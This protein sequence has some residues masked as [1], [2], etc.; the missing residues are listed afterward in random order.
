MRLTFITHD[1]PWPPLHGGRVDMWSRL[2]E[3]KRRGHALQLLS[4]GAEMPSAAE[5]K[6]MRGLADEAF[7]FRSRRDILRFLHPRYPG[8]VRNR[9]W[10]SAD[11]KAMFSAV[12]RFRPDALIADGTAVGGAALQLLSKLDPTPPL[13]L[14]SHNV[15]WLY[16]AMLGHHEKNPVAKLAY[17]VESM[18]LRFFER[19]LMCRAQRIFQIAR[20]DQLYWQSL[21]YDHQFTVPFLF[22]PPQE[23]PVSI[24]KKYDVLYLGNLGSNHKLASLIWFMRQ[25]RPLLPSELTIGIAGAGAPD[26][27]ELLCREFNCAYVGNVPDPKLVLQSGRVLIN[28]VRETCGINVKM[29]EML[30]SRLP[31]VSTSAGIRSYPDGIQNWVRLADTPADFAASIVMA[32]DNPPSPKDPLPWLN[33]HFGPQTLDLFLAETEKTALERR[34]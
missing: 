33:E 31:I 3:L 2:V 9:M 24:S 22:A 12:R 7:F 8:T 4:W 18:R 19:G 1:H 29:A 27:F 14:R 21:G 10:S 5:Q 15:E 25:V 26:A 23:E 16:Y 30:G 28:P 11:L 17:F 34:L 6:Y 20:D 32:L 13:L